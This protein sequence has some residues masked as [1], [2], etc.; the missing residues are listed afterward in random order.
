MLQLSQVEA[1]CDCA[2]ERVAEL[3][4]GGVV[5]HG[6]AITIMNEARKTVDGDAPEALNGDGTHR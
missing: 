5:I 6:T 2:R 3:A 4:R 1:E